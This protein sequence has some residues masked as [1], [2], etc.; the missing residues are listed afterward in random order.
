MEKGKFEKVL[1]D[2]KNERYAK[3]MLL[4]NKQIYSSK[5]KGK[6]LTL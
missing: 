1:I 4:Q 5:I 3:N 6:N 2:V